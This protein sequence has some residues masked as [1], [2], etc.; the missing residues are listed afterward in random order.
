MS[1]C[2][3]AP[4]VRLTLTHGSGRF[5]SDH[6]PSSQ[7]LVK[8]SSPCGLRQRVRSAIGGRAR[9]EPFRGYGPRSGQKQNNKFCAAGLWDPAFGRPSAL[10]S[11]H[12]RSCS[13]I[14]SCSRL[15][16]RVLRQD[17]SRAWSSWS[18]QIEMMQTVDQHRIPLLTE[19]LCSVNTVQSHLDSEH[20][21]E[22]EKR[23]GERGP[24]EIHELHLLLLPRYYYY[25]SPYVCV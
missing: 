3:H 23:E 8:A 2:V 9:W 6:G 25:M 7:G 21:L 11:H 4:Q 20:Q 19:A 24:I 22:R 5:S 16:K 17:P 12:T 10:A 15:G 18:S 14:C 13:R 1:E